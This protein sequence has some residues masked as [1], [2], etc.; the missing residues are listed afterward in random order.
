M[1][2]GA[3]YTAALA[4][5]GYFQHT[6]PTLTDN[7]EIWNGTAWTEV[8]NLNTRKR[9]MG[10][11]GTSTDAI[12]AGGSFHPPAPTV[13]ECE[14]WN[15]S[16]WTEL[17]DLSTARIMGASAGGTAAFVAGGGVAPGFTDVTE[18]L[19]ATPAIKT[20]TDS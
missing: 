8:A 18:E 14:Q 16:S 7:T 17:N 10:G 15:G 19:A 20:F 5:G 1:V 13:A 2:A 3:T 9:A 6:A 11:R 12:A 4:A